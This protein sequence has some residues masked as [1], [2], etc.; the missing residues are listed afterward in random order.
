MVEME[1]VHA[2]I[3]AQWE[4]G[5]CSSHSEWD[6]LYKLQKLHSNWYTVWYVWNSTNVLVLFEANVTEINSVK[7]YT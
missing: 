4:R 1:N 3:V 6:L 2:Q 5:S 7:C